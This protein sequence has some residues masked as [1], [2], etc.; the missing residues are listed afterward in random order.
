ML[1][2]GGF[3]IPAKLSVEGDQIRIYGG[4]PIHCD[5]EGIYQWSVEGETLTLTALEPIDPCAQR[6]GALDGLS[7]TR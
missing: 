5:G 1:N 3:S 7:Y 6:R 4:L 2:E